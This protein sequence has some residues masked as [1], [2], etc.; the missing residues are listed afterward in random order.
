MLN[1]G[2]TGNIAAG[3]STVAAAFERWGA[4]LIDADALVREVQSPGSPVLTAITKR[5]GTAMLDA[6]GA[7]DRAALRD[8][9]A[10]DEEALA[11][12]NALVHPAVQRRRDDL[13]HLAEQH[14]DLIVV[15]DIPLLFEV[16]DPE[17]FDVVVLIDA[18]EP[19]R[20][21]RLTTLRGLS[22]DDADRLIASQQPSPTKRSRSQ[23]VI[24]N[25]TSLD[26]VEQAAWTVWCALRR[27]AASKAAPRGGRLLAMFAHPDDE[28]FSIGGTL[29]RYADAGVDVHLWCATAGEAGTLHGERVSKEEL[30]AVRTKELSQV[31]E[32]LG[33]HELH[34]QEFP[35]G[36]LDPSDPEG[37][38][39]ATDVLQRLR[40]DIVVTFG[41]DGV[42]GHA[43]HLAVH[44]WSARAWVAA[45]L[46]GQ[47]YYVTYP[48]DVAAQLS[49]R[50]TGRPTNQITAR[51]DVRP[52]QDVKLA[53][54]QGHASQ[55][56][57]FP[58]EAPPGKQLLER[59]WFAGGSGGPVPLADLFGETDPA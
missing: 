19:V 3:K 14:G 43:D 42:T 35:D 54:I 48:E 56:F 45:G 49:S 31:V 24:D 15:N 32:V 12:L 7:L 41:P 34:L 8:A 27:D 30:R 52:W 33:I 16:L 59:E 29:A 28:T 25:V 6:G 23:F 55:R 38:A 50:L 36:R 37:H 1:V 13:Q 53:A 18:P 4:T 9:V 39:A 11:S 40:P 22:E 58:V 47:I 44:E 10:G 57:P 26:D 51:L 46:P 20:R 2:L 5:F 17:Q 21:S